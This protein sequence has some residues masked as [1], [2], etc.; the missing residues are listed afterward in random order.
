MNR[1]VIGSLVGVGVAVGASLAVLFL[2]G[3][4]PRRFVQER[5]RQVSG[6]L[7]DR[8]QVRQYARTATAGVSQF[9]GNAKSTAGQVM[10]KVRRAGGDEGEKAGQLALAGNVREN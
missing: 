7:P 4:K 1:W 3:E 2:G 5:Y 8:E 6:A 10:K 9:A